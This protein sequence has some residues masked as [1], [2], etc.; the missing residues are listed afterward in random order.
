MLG[1]ARKNIARTKLV[2][3]W[4]G[5]A[6]LMFV[7]FCGGIGKFIVDTLLFIHF[8]ERWHCDL[9]WMHITGL[10]V[11]NSYEKKIFIITS[12]LWLET[13]HNGVAVLIAIVGWDF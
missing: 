11:Q 12:G 4:E 3:R 8:V 2:E 10:R 5:I 1:E 7:I 9:D 13:R 6:C